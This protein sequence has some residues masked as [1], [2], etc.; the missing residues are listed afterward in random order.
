MRLARRTV[1]ALVLV[2]A[3]PA[4]WTGQD[5]DAAQVDLGRSSYTSMCVRCHGMNLV[6]N[7]I[8]FDLRTFPAGDKNRFIRSVTQGKRAMPAWGGTIKPEQ[9][10]AIWA[11]IGSVNGWAAGPDAAASK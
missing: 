7:G 5:G 11:Y 10:D 1:L 6:S 8:G 4:A 2:A 9:I 3:Q